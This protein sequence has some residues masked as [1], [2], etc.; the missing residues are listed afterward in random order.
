L[1][2]YTVR[3]LQSAQRNI[4]EK[5]TKL[6][7]IRPGESIAAA[8]ALERFQPFSRFRAALAGGGG[9]Q[10]PRLVAIFRYSPAR[11]EKF[12]KIDLSPCI[13]FFDGHP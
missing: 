5:N 9:K 12:G 2:Q 10:D 13:S 6:Q 11:A 7:R 4:R 8:L 1:E 3:V